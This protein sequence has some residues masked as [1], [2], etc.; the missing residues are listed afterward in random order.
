MKK[1]LFTIIACCLAIGTLFAQA[2]YP[3]NLTEEKRQ[4]EIPIRDH[5]DNEHGRIFISINGETDDRGNTPVSIQLQNT[6]YDYDFLLCDHAWN[7]KELRK[8]FIHFDKRYAGESTKSVENVGL[9]NPKVLNIISNNS[10]GKY[11]FTNVYVEEGKE[12]EVKIPVHLLKPKP[13]LFCRKRKMLYGA[14]LCTLRITVD[15]KDPVYEKLQ[16]EYDSLFKAFTAAL[17]HEEFCTH[18][19]H[20]PSLDEQ[21]EEYFDMRQNLENQIWESYQKCQPGSKKSNRYEGLY[22]A[23]HEMR[24]QMEDRLEHYKHDCGQH[25]IAPATCKYCDRSL[26]EISRLMENLYYDLFNGVKTKPEVLKEARKLYHCCINHKK[27]DRQ[28]NSSEYKKTIMDYYN[29]IKNWKD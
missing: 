19:K 5:G 29:S 14:I 23:I 6:S 10:D 20:D 26:E 15:T 3:I 13:G 27:Q 28:W 1:S 4:D 16:M 12:L 25:K 21:T 18:P 8:Q 9:K 2:P 7:K 24:H 11:T 17:D 22:D